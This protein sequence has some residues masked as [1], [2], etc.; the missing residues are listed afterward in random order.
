MT[1]SI[2][3][4]LLVLGAILWALR[5]LKSGAALMA[6][7]AVGYAS[8]ASAVLPDYFLG[9]MQAPYASRAPEKIA[10]GTALVVFGL[11]TQAVREQGLTTVEPM[12]FAFGPILKAAALYRQCGRDGARCHVVIAGGDVARTGLSEAASIAAQL[13]AA[14]VDPAAMRLDETSRNSWENA[15][16][17]AVLLRELR[18]TRVILVQSAPMLER[19]LLYLKHFGVEAE[20]VAAAYLTTTTTNMAATSLN[21]LAADLVL[22]ERLGLWRYAFYNAMGWNAPPAPPPPLAAA[23]AG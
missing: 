10:D 16:D 1:L 20:P 2:L 22:Y 4:F 23:P 17:V 3:V 12:A 8:V 7:A 15:R 13:K 14:G 11:G 18:P 5:W 9:R 19:D 21:F 6:L